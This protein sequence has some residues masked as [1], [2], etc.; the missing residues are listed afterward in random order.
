MQDLRPNNVFLSSAFEPTSE[1]MDAFKRDERARSRARPSQSKG[2]GS[3]KR[4]VDS[5]SDSDSDSE[6]TTKSKKPVVRGVEFA[7]LTDSDD[8]M[9]DM[10][11]ILKEM[12]DRKPGK[13]G[14]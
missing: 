11:T 9:P 5:D 3:R 10:E 13:K 2:T 4:E 14:K 6:P 1:E 12:T 8:D 7:E